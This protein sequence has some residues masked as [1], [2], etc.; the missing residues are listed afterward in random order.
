[1]AAGPVPIRVARAR[2]ERPL[3]YEELLR[4]E[5]IAVSSD[6][7]DQ[8][9]VIGLDDQHALAFPEQDV[10]SGSEGDARDGGGSNST[11]GGGGS[12]DASQAGVEQGRHALAHDPIETD[13]QD[14]R[15]PAI[16][17]QP[18]PQ[19]TKWGLCALCGGALRVVYTNARSGFAFLGCNK[20]QMRNPDSCRYTTSLP[21]SRW[22]ELPV[23]VRIRRRVNF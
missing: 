1:M 6:E 16:V 4:A 9:N 18:R 13:S 22:N 10:P 23:R 15:E 5:P 19:V 11:R 2:L 14:D 20:Y 8:G 3:P 12:S 7:E 17:R 21:P